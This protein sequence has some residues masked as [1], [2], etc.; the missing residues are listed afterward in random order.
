MYKHLA[1]VLAAVPAPS[2]V[3]A[4]AAAAAAAAV[5]ANNGAH[6]R[7]HVIQDTVHS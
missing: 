1:V 2:C 7:L 3:R 5:A 6:T 4:A